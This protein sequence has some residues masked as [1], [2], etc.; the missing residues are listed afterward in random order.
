MW[1][2]IIP[3]LL[4][5]SVGM[6]IAIL[7]VWFLRSRFGCG[8]SPCV[9]AQSRCGLHEYLNARYND[10]QEWVLH[11]VTAREMYNIAVAAMDGASGDPG[12]HRD[13]VVPPPPICAR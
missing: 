7:G 2:K 12:D 4:V 6:N 9:Q 11:Y 5:L 13:H 1:R 10:G 8:R 3:L